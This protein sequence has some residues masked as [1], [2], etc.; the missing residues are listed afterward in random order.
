MGVW[1]RI[2]MWMMTGALIKAGLPKDLVD[3]VSGDAAV[4]MAVEQAVLLIIGVLMGWIA[5]AW[6]KIALRLGWST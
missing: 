6:R 3:I 2:V 4:H 5:L 1:V